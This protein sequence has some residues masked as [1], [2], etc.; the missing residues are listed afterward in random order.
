MKNLS[1]IHK[2]I[3]Q[4]SLYRQPKSVL[5]SQIISNNH[6]IRS[7]TLTFQR[8]FRTGSLSSQATS[9]LEQK[10]QAI[11]TSVH[12]K[13][14]PA[15]TQPHL[16][17]DP[18]R[19]HEDWCLF[20]P[21]YEPDELKQVKIVRH[22]PKDLSDRIVSSLV[23][24]IRLGFDTV[25]RYKHPIEHQ[26]NSGKSLNEMRQKGLVMTP[27]QWMARILFL[28]SIA[29][30]P[31]MVAAM[32]RHFRSLRMSGRDGGWIRTLLEE[33]EN[34]RMHLL[35]F[36]KI[37]QP[38]IIFRAMVLG[39]QGVFA[40]LFFLSYL[41]SPRS[42]H[43]FVG[44]LEE[45]AV[46]TYSLA[47]RELETGRLP[48]WENMPAPQIAVDYWRLTP[49]SKMID[50]LY[51]VRA[52]ESNH[53]FVNHSLANIDAASMNP[54]AIKQPNAIIRGTIPGFKRQES[55]AWA[56]QVENEVVTGREA[57]QLNQKSIST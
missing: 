5:A 1:S 44:I 10:N 27:Q 36:M 15:F 17:T 50:V 19:A 22:E 35:T 6:S 28:E 18:S 42:A 51:A 41:I 26:E 54:F 9:D 43:R 38:G 2:L 14:S 33:A 8:T 34:E 45:E 21:V 57:V 47:I 16:P 55:E 37:R 3:V 20:H 32:L 23:K 40:N 52:D 11:N 4:A 48:E 12:F 56:R 49:N 7:N 39:A 30:V 46:V 13:D 53:R 31:G 24:L 25:T 29:G